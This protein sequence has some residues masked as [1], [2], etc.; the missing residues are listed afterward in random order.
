[1]QGRYLVRAAAAKMGLYGN[2]LEEAYYPVAETDA[3]GNALDASQRDY[4]L[5][6]SKEELPSVQGFWSITL[7]KLP[8][9]L[10]VANPINRYSIGDRTPGLQYGED[11]SLTLYIQH[12]SPGAD[13][14]SNWLPTNAG[15]F[16]LQMRMYWPA[17]EALEGPYAPPPA[18][19]EHEPG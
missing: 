2:D 6:F 14:E 17:P 16:S 8:E 12:A 11:G 3:G 9:Q 5:H 19:T 10:L 4:F 15:P 18:T 13:K 7:Y 1:M